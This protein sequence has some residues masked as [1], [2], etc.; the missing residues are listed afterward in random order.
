[1][2]PEQNRVVEPQEN[3]NHRFSIGIG[4][5]LGVG[6]GIALDNLPVGIGVG[7]A[8]G[9]ALNAAIRRKQYQPAR[10]RMTRRLV[11]AGASW[12]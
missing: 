2:D 10:T 1:M 4:F 7:L 11:C 5:I 12:E 9:A 8:L 3:K 6:V